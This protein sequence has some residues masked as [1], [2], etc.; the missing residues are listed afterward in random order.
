MKKETL[1]HKLI[2]KI[3]LKLGIV[4]SKKISKKEMCERAIKSNVCPH[5]CDICAWNEDQDFVKEGGVMYGGYFD[6]KEAAEE[7]KEK[8]ELY[9]MI[10]FF[11]PVEKKWCLIFDL[12]VRTSN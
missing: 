11:S 5:T 7:Y 10:P 12:K 2:T 1:L 6:T 9:V 8:H 4:E 3:F